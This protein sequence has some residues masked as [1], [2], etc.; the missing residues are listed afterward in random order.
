MHVSSSRHR[1]RT[2]DVP[3]HETRSGEEDDEPG[4]KRRSGYKLGQRNRAGRSSGGPHSASQRRPSLDEIGQSEPVGRKDE[5]RYVRCG[6]SRPRGEQ[7]DV[8]LANRVRVSDSE[9][10]HD[11][12]CSRVGDEPTHDSATCPT[13]PD[14][15]ANRRIAVAGTQPARASILRVTHVARKDLRDTTSHQAR[16]YW[17]VTGAGLVLGRGD[18]STLPQEGGDT[19]TQQVAGIASTVGGAGCWV[20]DAAGNIRCHGDAQ[21]FASQRFA[22][23]VVDIATSPRGGFWLTTTTGEVHA[24]GGAPALGDLRQ[25]GVEVSNIVAIVASA[26]RGYWLVGAEGGV[27]SFGDA[28]FLGSLPELRITG[29]KVVDATAPAVGSGYHLLGEDGAVYS[30]GD[31]PFC[32][33]FGT[34]GLAA[35]DVVAIVSCPEGY[36]VCGRDG[37]M[38]AFGQAPFLGPIQTNDVVDC[39]GLVSPTALAG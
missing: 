13:G 37:W 35:P 10:G 23:P 20:V 25:V 4:Q 38:Y 27:Y 34:V 21:D 11:D 36:W 7:D 30:F 3:R 31:A 12:E 39:C 17:G 22:A 8:V 5:A 26:A 2:D 29:A 32:G 19:L 16:G 6:P 24:V 15:H 9:R 18:A 28:A 14:A 1:G 33:S